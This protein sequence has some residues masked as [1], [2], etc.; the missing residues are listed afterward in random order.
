M[1]RKA[2]LGHPL[3]C[4]PKHCTVSSDGSHRS[5][6]LRIPEAATLYLD[7]VRDGPTLIMVK[8]HGHTDDDLYAERV[9]LVLGVL[10]AVGVREHL[11]HLIHAAV[12]ELFDDDGGGA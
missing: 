2:K 9:V 3:W 1:S 7:Q 12:H 5:T 10:E 6:P 4:D 11:D 8:R